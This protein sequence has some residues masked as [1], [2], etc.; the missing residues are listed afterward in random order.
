MTLVAPLAILTGIWVWKYRPWGDVLAGIFLVK[1][2]TIMTSFLIADY[3]NWFAGTATNQGAII[4][5]SAIYILVYI[6]LWNYFS[7]FKNRKKE[8][9]DHLNI[10]DA[11]LQTKIIL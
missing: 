1:A 9:K 5:F 2:I 10:D 8:S 3:I 6:F 7:A 4:T 11:Y